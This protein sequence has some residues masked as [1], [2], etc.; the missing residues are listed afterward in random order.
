MYKRQERG[1]DTWEFWFGLLE[2]Y[3]AE[4]GDCRVPTDHVTGDGSKLGT[5][6][7]N[8]RAR[9]TTMPAER[10]VRLEALPG[11]TWDARDTKW[12]EGFARLEAYV[13]DKGHC[14]VAANHVTSDGYRLGGWL[15]TQRTKSTTMTADRR[16]RLKALQG[17]TWDVRD[18]AWEEGFTQLVAYVAG[19]GDCRVPRSHVTSDGYRLGNWVTD[20]RTNRTTMPAERRSRV[21]ALPDWISRDR[22]APRN[23]SEKA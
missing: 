22:P 17:W 15:V 23:A 13:A 6:V 10:K 16:S 2:A 3:A 5:W 18:D 11:W 20:Q 12:E 9:R 19:K 21:E 8:Q 14:L 7:H 1:T 4:N